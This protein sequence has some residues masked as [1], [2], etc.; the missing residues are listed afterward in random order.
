MA[1]GRGKVLAL[2]ASPQGAVQACS[3]MQ[4][5]TPADCD[6]LARAS[7]MAALADHVYDPENRELPEGYVWLDPDDPEDADELYGT[8]LLD[9]STLEPPDSGFKAAVYKKGADYVVA[10]RGTRFTEKEDWFNNARQG[11]GMEPEYYTNAMEVAKRANLGSGGKVAFA[12]H[13]LGG[14]M[15]SAA[16]VATGRPAT[17]FNAAGLSNRTVD[18]FKGSNPKVDAYYVKGEVLSA[19]QD[20]RQAVLAGIGGAAAWLSSVPVLGPALAVAGGYVLGREVGDSPV[21]PKAYGDRHPLPASPPAGETG[22]HMVDKHGMAWASSG[23]ETRQRELG[24]P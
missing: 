17:T 22:G 8:L 21:L 16:A 23:I 13:S 14:G 2:P 1:S 11:M 5:A 15:A 10:Y 24:C 19:V 4:K 9:K 20:N 7:D 6:D 18:G 12:G 3:P